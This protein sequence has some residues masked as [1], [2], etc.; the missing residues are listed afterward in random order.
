M[1]HLRTACTLDCPDACSLDI[2]VEDGAVVSIGA[3]E[4]NSLTEGFICS[5]VKRFTRHQYG[6]DRLRYP[7]RRNR[8]AGSKAAAGGRSGDSGF[9]RISWDEALSEIAERMTHIRSEYGGEA[10]VPLA[11]GGS[12]GLITQDTVDLQLFDRLGAS[13]VA[14]T[15]CAA[16]ST[17]AATALYGKMAGVALQDYEHARLIVVWGA[18][19]S[20]TGIHLVPI[21]RR[22][23]KNGA[24][25]VV[26]DPRRTPLAKKADLHIQPRPGT[27][28]A[29][30]MAMHHSLFDTGSQSATFLESH[31]RGVAEL[32]EAAS[33]WPVERA[34]KISGVAADLIEEFVELY[35]SLEPAVIRCGWGVE[36]NRNG[37]S[38]VAAILALPAVAG[39]FGRRGGGYTLSNGGAWAKAG[40]NTVRAKGQGRV[41]NMNHVG[42]DLLEVDDPPIKLLFVYNHNPLATLP[43]QAQVRRGLERDD[44]FTVVF[45][46]VMTDTAQYADIVL[47]A[48][49]FL[50]HD[51]LRLSYGSLTLQR[52]QPVVSPVGESRSNVEVFGQLLERTLGTEPGEDRILSANELTTWI[53]GEDLQAGE[54]RF[55]PGGERP[56]QFVD[57]FP[58]TA[59][60]R[61]DLFPSALNRESKVGL[62]RYIEA[63]ADDSYPLTL[64]SP[65]T[66]H[67]V[68]STFGQFLAKAV[69]EIH[70]DDAE[71][72]GVESGA[73][74]RVFNEQGEVHC[75]SRLNPDLRPGTAL[76]P[77]GLW[78]R[79]SENGNT[80]NTLVPDSLTDIGA[81][82]CFNDA[83][84]EVES[85]DVTTATG[86]PPA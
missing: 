51:D 42:R 84:V 61:A 82:A 18:N 28:L 36:R 66:E 58:A 35:E 45:D 50:E 85:L 75:T 68:S 38:A 7:L 64:I 12:N 1:P 30:A 37:G 44:L 5:K 3:G 24:R 21:I 78:S 72:R 46:Q 57:V 11:Y 15:V 4:A 23:Q 48:T 10:I 31:C 70:P 53:T 77:K 29:V 73:A 2:L 41:L 59:D 54:V 76:L 63:P 60:G 71:P 13:R 27:D 43:A 62:Y 80:S 8:Q 79:S 33:R 19:P 47:P 67:T 74:V 49:T 55:P 52:S 40:L 34:A 81:G 6:A 83:R 25:L 65:A 69:L 32:R 9:T 56:I 20:V 39:K 26:V 22:A 14:R 86:G 17:S 16:P